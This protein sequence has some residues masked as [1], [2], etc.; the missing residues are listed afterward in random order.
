VW[1]VAGIFE[2]YGQ[3]SRKYCS[4]NC[5]VEHRFKQGR[6]TGGKMLG[7][8]LKDGRLQIV[9]E[10]AEIVRQIFADYL[11]GMGRNVIA[12]KLSIER[13]YV[14]SYKTVS[15]ILC[16][17]KYRGDLLLQKTYRKDYLSKK[18]CVNRGELPQYHVQ[19]SHEPII[20]PAMFDEVQREWAKRAGKYH[21]SKEK[22]PTYPFSN[23]IIC[24]KCAIHYQR[25]HT[26]AGTKYDKIV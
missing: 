18:T 24:E 3:K 20:P 12:N 16:N 6:P 5:Y 17:E 15:K 25:K 4:H 14:W 8:R 1:A 22:P 21:P 10:E 9:P 19:G 26:A 11:S 23:R 2:R 7:Y 13:D